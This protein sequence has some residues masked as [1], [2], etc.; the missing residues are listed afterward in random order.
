MDNFIVTRTATTKT[1]S[2]L[3]LYQS[4]TT[5]FRSVIDP[6]WY[7]VKTSGAN[8]RQFVRRGALIQWLLTRELAL[9]QPLI[10]EG[11]YTTQRLR[12]TYQTVSH[13]DISVFN[14]LPNVI[15]TTKV[16]SK[17]QYTL[18]KIIK[19]YNIIQIHFAD[20]NTKRQIFDYDSI[21]E[22]MG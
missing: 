4:L 21:N 22:T 20:P 3:W 12:G 17:G 9:T 16:I 13:N 18:A 6:Y 7:Q 1:Y 2:N 5:S 15:A 10:D 14:D 11:F 19:Q 8:H